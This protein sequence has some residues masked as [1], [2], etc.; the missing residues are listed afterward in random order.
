MRVAGLCER[1]LGVLGVRVVGVR[2]EE[3]AR[4]GPTLVVESARPAARGM[5]CSGCGQVVGAVHGRS[6]RG[7][8]HRDGPARP[9]A[10]DR[11]LIDGLERAHQ[12]G[13]RALSV[14]RATARAAGWWCRARPG[15][16]PARA[17]GHRGPLARA[18]ALHAP[19]GHPGPPATSILDTVRLRLSNG[20][21]EAMTSTVRLL[22]HRSRGFRR[23]DNPIALIHLV[24]GR[25]Q[26][27]LPT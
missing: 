17:P 9:S 13:Y 7:W 12:E 15:G 23:R 22:S 2:L 20:R 18:P 14:G 24:C 8:R 10:A 16:R 4:G 25:A 1:L 6:V 26:I 5:A 21:I 11:G 19:G 27:A 3:R